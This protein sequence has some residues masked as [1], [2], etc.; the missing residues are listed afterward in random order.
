MPF[1]KCGL[2]AAL[3]AACKDSLPDFMAE[4]CQPGGEGRRPGYAVF[5]GRKRSWRIQTGWSRL[6][7]CNTKIADV[8]TLIVQ[9][10]PNPEAPNAK[11]VGDP[12]TNQ[13]MQADGC[14]YRSG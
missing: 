4:I 9:V 6:R 7:L 12:R 11:L 3:P 5:R 8:P 13:G 10:M 1:E 14:K 2:V